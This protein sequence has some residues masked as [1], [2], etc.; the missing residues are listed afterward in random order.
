MHEKYIQES[1]N[2]IKKLI[3]K[4]NCNKTVCESLSTIKVPYKQSLC[5]KLKIQTENV[6][7]CSTVS[8]LELL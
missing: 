1:D 4:T 3:L 7:S 6:F 8:E 2:C 5:F